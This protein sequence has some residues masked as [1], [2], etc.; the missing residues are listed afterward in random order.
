MMEKYCK[1]CFKYYDD[2][3]ELCPHCGYIDGAEPKE[4]NHLFVG[5]EL[6][7]RYVIGNVLG[8]GGFGIT[9]KAW[10]K[11]LETAVA[12]KEYY[13]CGIVNRP[14]GTKNILLF[15]GNRKKEFEH[16]LVRFIDEA[17]NTIKFNAHRNIVNVYEYFE[18]NSTAYFVMEFL[19]GCDLSDFIESSKGKPDIE[20]SMDIIMSVCNALKDI[21]ANGI[22]HRDISPDNIYLTNDGGVKL[23]DFGA[24]RFSSVEEK[25]FT[26]VLKPGFA[27]PEQYEQ[28]SEQGPKT[29]IYALG[30]TLYYCI[31]GVKPEESTN[32]KTNDTL[33]LPK[34][35]N[36]DIEQYLSD[37]IMKAM[38][39]EPALR[40]ES[41]DEFQKAIKKEIK[42]KA[43]SVEKK[44]R[45]IKR[46]TGVLVLV[47]FLSTV[48]GVFF[49]DMNKKKEQVTLDA[50][51]INV[52]YISDNSEEQEKSYQDI[53]LS[54]CKEYPDVVVEA[55]GYSAIE[56]Q[57]VL[58]DIENETS[59]INLFVSDNMSEGQLSSMLDLYSVVYSEDE[60]GSLSRFFNKFGGN[61]TGCS[62]LDD[63]EK[64]FPECKQVPIGF[65]APVIYVNTGYVDPE[66]ETIGELKD[67]EE[68]LNQGDSIIVDSE[69]YDEFK[70]IFGESNGIKI[71]RGTIKDF[72]N[73]SAKICFSSTSNFFEVRDMTNSGVG[74]PR[75]LAIDGDLPCEFSTY[76]SVLPSEDEA[77]N[78]AAVAFLSYMLSHNAQNKLLGE[79]KSSNALP[80]NDDSLNTFVAVFDEFEYVIK[81]KDKFKF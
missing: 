23:I 38:A 40:F 78:Q 14:P 30:A 62:I 75:L 65:N 73:G 47:V 57:D 61:E 18:E 26:I 8:F 80:I 19:D 79:N 46:L 54:F 12:I 32:R 21:H 25:N 15:S 17:R 68:Y 28:I 33:P 20:K 45:K 22:I 77:E 58:A 43:P 3:F 35:I 48:L 76:W 24:A 1:G 72:T 34:S 52:C 53:I 64:Y 74:I 13:P 66:I 51:K 27:P 41:V 71:K 44:R 9:Y 36:P 70:E 4:P 10:D 56:Y 55:C 37:S 69:M 39:I 60:G 63:Y 81:E 16:G 49:S 5:T 59:D 7:G 31:T 11:K 29:D 6:A 2:E 50:A 42:V 67:L